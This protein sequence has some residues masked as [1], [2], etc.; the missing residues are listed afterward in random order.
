M[1][2]YAIP[3]DAEVV[4]STVPFRAF[5]CTQT[6]VFF[7][8]LLTKLTCFH[9]Y[10]TSLYIHLRTALACSPAIDHYVTL[11]HLIELQLDLVPIHYTLRAHPPEHHKLQNH[12]KPY[13][14]A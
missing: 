3:L 2:L 9:R 13:S 14:N 1:R 4:S 10:D 6:E 5:R 7:K 12:L 11:Y 8:T